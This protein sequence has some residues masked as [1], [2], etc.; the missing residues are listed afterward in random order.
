[1][2]PPQETEAEL[3]RFRRQWQEEVSK[4]AKKP[5]ASQQSATPKTD[6]RK[7]NAAPPSSLS[8]APLAPKKQTVQQDSHEEVDPRAYHDL[9]DKEAELRLD[10][11][12]HGLIRG[13]STKIEPNSALEHSERAVE[14]EATGSLGDSL[15]HYRKAFKVGHIAFPCRLPVVQAELSILNHS[16]TMACMNNTKT[17]ISL[18]LPFHPSNQLHRRRRRRRTRSPCRPH[19]RKQA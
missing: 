14:K 3:E 13:S 16:S 8:S 4:K 2:D 7:Q 11:A 18:H 1:M 10:A 5:S 19:P 6:R 12:D 15:K 9:P 17:N